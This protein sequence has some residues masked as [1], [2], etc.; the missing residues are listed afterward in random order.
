MKET[1]LK[2]RH[3]ISPSQLRS[4][5]KY[6]HF[7]VPRNWQQLD[8]VA[9][10]HNRLYRFRWRAQEGFLVDISFPLQDFDRWANSTHI[11][12]NYQT[13]KQQYLQK[14]KPLFDPKL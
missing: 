3:N 9:Q 10:K 5:L 14:A 7:Q 12:M 8:Y 6:H 11:K 13:F 1:S 2:I 4:L